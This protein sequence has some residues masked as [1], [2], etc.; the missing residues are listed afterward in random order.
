MSSSPLGL[1]IIFC[2]TGNIESILCQLG[3]NETRVRVR[4]TIS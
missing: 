3:D 2:K 4:A 1:S